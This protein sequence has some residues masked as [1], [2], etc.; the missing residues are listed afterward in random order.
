ME[1]SAADRA[2]VCSCCDNRPFNPPVAIADDA[3]FYWESMQTGYGPD[4]ESFSEKNC[5]LFYCTDS[6]YVTDQKQQTRVETKFVLQ[7]SRAGYSHETP[8]W[9]PAPELKTTVELRPEGKLQP[10][11]YIVRINGPENEADCVM[12]KG[13]GVPFPGPLIAVFRV[14]GTPAAP[15]TEADDDKMDVEKPAA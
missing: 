3:V 11:C 8:R 10:G 2:A 6:V 4:Q 5:Q 9:E 1:R 14:P 15:T 7:R 12:T 13:A